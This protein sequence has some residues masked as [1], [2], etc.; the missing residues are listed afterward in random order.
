[1]QVTRP[2]TASWNHQAV[3][4]QPL[5]YTRAFFDL[6]ITLCSSSRTSNGYCYKQEHV[7]NRNLLHE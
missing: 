2:L 3:Y 5:H 7:E 4:R 1:M 6:Q